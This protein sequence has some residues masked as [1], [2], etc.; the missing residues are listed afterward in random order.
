MKGLTMS[1]ISIGDKVVLSKNG[2]KRYKDDSDN[3]H[4]MIG[5]LTNDER[6]WRGKGDVGLLVEWANGTTNN[7][8]TDDLDKWDPPKFKPG[9]RIEFDFATAYLHA[10]GGLLVRPVGSM[11]IF[12]QAAFDAPTGMW[13]TQVVLGKW[14]IADS[15]PPTGPSKRFKQGDTVIKADLRATGVVLGYDRRGRLYVDVAGADGVISY[16]DGEWN[17]LEKDT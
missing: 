8:C 15:L 5:T 13:P 7:Y 9:W 10:K 17:L 1:T 12:D 14:E 2:R 4:Y 3:P 16:E 11:S 6:A